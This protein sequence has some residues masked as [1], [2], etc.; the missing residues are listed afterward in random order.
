[1]DIYSTTKSFPAFIFTFSAPARLRITNS[2]VGS[3]CDHVSRRYLSRANP[4]AFRVVLK[5][6]EGY[7]VHD[8]REFDVTLGS[9]FAIGRASK[10]TSKGYLLPAKHNVY[11]DSPVISREHAI[12]TANASSGTPKVYITDTKSMHGTFVNGT[13]LVP[14]TPKQLSNGDKLQFGINVNRNESESIAH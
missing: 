2:M 7:D 5:Q 12:L 1:M 3:K 8:V 14:N 13:P 9:K 4:A 10:N 6:D 11:I